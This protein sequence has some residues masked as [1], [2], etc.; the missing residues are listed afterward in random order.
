MFCN[1]VFSKVTA[2][3]KILKV[4]LANEVGVPIEEHSLKGMLNL[5]KKNHTNESIYKTK[6]DP[7]T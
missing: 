6:T 4:S 5:K 1:I 7:Q 3:G 2:K